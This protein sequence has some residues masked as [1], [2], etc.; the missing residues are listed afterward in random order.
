MSRAILFVLLVVAYICISNVNACGQNEQF[1][2][3][4]GCDQRCGVE[5]IEC[6]EVCQPGCACIKG[7]IRNAA[8]KCVLPKHC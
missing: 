1:K 4:G 2:E 3:C 7:F 8:N 6:L 5:R